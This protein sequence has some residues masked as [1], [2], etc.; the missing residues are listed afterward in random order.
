MGLLPTAPL[1]LFSTVCGY[2]TAGTH[3]NHARQR[4]DAIWVGFLTDNGSSAMVRMYGPF[5]PSGRLLIKMETLSEQR[6]LQRRAF[7]GDPLVYNIGQWGLMAWGARKY[8][9]LHG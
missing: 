7:P 5:K 2:G 9:R 3:G 1:Q 6:A 4:T 8:F